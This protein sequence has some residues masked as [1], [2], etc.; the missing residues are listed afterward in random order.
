VHVLPTE[1]HLFANFNQVQ[2][3]EHHDGIGDF[4]PT[5][6]HLYRDG[7][8]IPITDV[9]GFPAFR[10]PPELG[11]YRLTLDDPPV[12]THSEWT[13]HSATATDNATLPGVWCPADILRTA[14]PCQPEPLVYLSYDMS[15]TLSMDNSVPAGR[16][17]VFTVSA[18]HTPTRTAEPKITDL[19]LWTST[20][21]GAHW[22][23]ARV[24]RTANGTFGAL[25]IYPDY[26]RTTGAVSL[27]VT[28]RDADGNTVTQTSLRAFNLHDVTPTNA[29]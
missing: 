4:A 24:W 10:L 13:F 19:R 23:P 28:A 27:K 11:A 16:A 8:E 3:F 12:R 18:Y 2:G 14:A 20:D 25:A 7:Q 6:T 15:A 9:G 21:D 5:L 26:D 22:R 29:Q 17:H 1:Q